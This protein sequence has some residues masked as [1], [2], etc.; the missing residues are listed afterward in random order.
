MQ[1]EL[2]TNVENQLQNPFEQVAKF[3]TKCNEMLATTFIGNPHSHDNRKALW[4]TFGPN[5]LYCFSVITLCI[6]MAMFQGDDDFDEVFFLVMYSGGGGL[7][8]WL[9]TTFAITLLSVI[10]AFMKKCPP[11]WM[12]IGPGLGVAISLITN[13]FFVGIIFNEADLFDAFDDL[14]LQ[15]NGF[16]MIFALF[17]THTVLALAT[18]KMMV[19]VTQNEDD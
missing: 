18:T 4:L 10:V 12:I 14:F 3:W 5:L 7:F 13:I 16:A 8:V 17:F 6:F 2:E 9:F 11:M 19:T 1:D 15:V